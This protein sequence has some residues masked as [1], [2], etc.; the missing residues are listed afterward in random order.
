VLGTFDNKVDLGWHSETTP[1]GI[2]PLI[3][4]GVITG[5]HKTLNP[6]KAI[7]TACGGGSKEDMDFVTMNPAFELHSAEY[8]LD[9]RV[10]AQ[11]DNMVTVNS[12]VSVDF[13]GQIAAESIGPR[14][15]SGAGGQTAFAIGSFLSK[16][17]RSITVLT[18]T[19]G[20][21]E[22]RVSRIT[23]LLAEGTIVTVP[24]TI[25][26]YVV[27]EYGIA[28]IKSKTQRQRAL[29]LIDI[30]HPDFRAELKKE[31]EKLYWP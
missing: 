5:K 4:K 29:A 2:I 20:S 25:S 15:I 26:D 17:G 9:V 24:R 21:G 11:H 23:P 12:A 19:A 22:K 6:N 7:A 1:R 3:R 16:G 13:A 14:V 10:I 8:C 31:A 28:H 27:T 18:S 30:A